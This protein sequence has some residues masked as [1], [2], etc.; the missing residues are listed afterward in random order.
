MDNFG[1]PAAFETII[2]SYLPDPPPAGALD[3]DLDLFAAGIDS[4]ATIGLLVDLENN[5]NFKFPDELLSASTFA[6][7]RILWTALSTAWSA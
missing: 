2:R 3:P 4:L 7:P 6:T 5:F 1:W